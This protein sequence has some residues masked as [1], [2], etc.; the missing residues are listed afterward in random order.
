MKSSS[1]D[2]RNK[3]LFFRRYTKGCPLTGDAAPVID[4]K[5]V[6]LLLRFVSTRGRVLPR[7]ITGVCSSKHRKLVRA[8]KT[9][10]I[11]ALLPFSA[12]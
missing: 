10:R 12:T 8:I 9:A 4:Y 7:R 2:T 6:K 1:S 11:L 3:K 5:D